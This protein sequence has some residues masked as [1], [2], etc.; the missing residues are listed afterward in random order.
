M[1]HCKCSDHRAHE[2][3][4]TDASL[5]RLYR[6]HTQLA[7][8]VA[9]YMLEAGLKRSLRNANATAMAA[10]LRIWNG[11]PTDNYPDCAIITNKYLCTGVLVHPRIVLTAAH[12]YS[13]GIT[14]VGLNCTSLLDPKI[15]EI[16]VQRFRVHPLYTS[17][18]TH[19]IAVLILQSNSNTP[20][21]P[22]ATSQ[23]LNN[24]EETTLVGFGR[25]EL[26]SSGEKR[27]VTVP[28]HRH[29]DINEAEARLVFE[30]DYEF[31]A[32]GSGFDSCN[33]DS[34]GPGYISVNNRFKLAGLTS[35]GY[36]GGS[37]GKG[38]IY[39]R[40]DAHRDFIQQVAEE[41]GINFV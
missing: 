28:I 30:S 27:K 21:V 25:T 38:G 10:N 9:S 26:G 18:G 35:R 40:V 12:C 5:E 1:S 13:G 15:E 17:S 20:H 32:G 4:D 14:K 2:D 16:S 22:L 31:T 19:D 3:F 41:S 8:T 36:P 6:K 29:N 39:T 33:G 34:G 24:A 37:C 23:E 11:E 7:D